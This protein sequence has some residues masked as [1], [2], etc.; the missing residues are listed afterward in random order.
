MSILK[1]ED[2]ITDYDKEYLALILGLRCLFF[3]NSVISI[4]LASY[5]LSLP[6]KETCWGMSIQKHYTRPAHAVCPVMSPL[7]KN[8]FIHRR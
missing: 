1:L 7:I 6:Y 2:I 3:P 5:L 4:I 8:G